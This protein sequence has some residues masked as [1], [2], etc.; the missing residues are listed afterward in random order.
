MCLCDGG[1]MDG[2][3]AGVVHTVIHQK[4]NGANSD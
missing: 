3:R 2:F 1:V 4:N